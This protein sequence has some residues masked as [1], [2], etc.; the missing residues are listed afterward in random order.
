[1]FIRF[2]KLIFSNILSFG[3]EKTTID[4]SQG[5]HLIVGQNG[6]GKSAILDAL[7]FCLFGQPYRKIKIKEL[8]NRKNRR[9]T[10]VECHFT[11]DNND[12][13]IVIRQIKPDRISILKN[14]QELDLL[15]SKKLNQDE[16]DKIIGIDY[17]MFKQVI[18]L[19]VNYNKPFLSLPAM[20]KRDIVE[21]IFNIK[22]FGQMM[23]IHK[24]NNTDIRI[25]VDMN[26]QSLTIYEE[27]IKSLRRRLKETK[28]ATENFEKNK[29][30]DVKNIQDRI[31]QKKQNKEKLTNDINTNKSLFDAMEDCSDIDS[32][33]EDREDIINKI[34]EKE[35]NV[36]RFNKNIGLIDKNTV[37]T[38]CNQDITNEV[39]D[40]EISRLKV[41]I[42]K[43]NNALE[44][45]R[46]ERITIEQSIDKKEKI[47]KDKETIV[48]DNQ[49]KQEQIN[50]ID[51]EI[52]HLL[53]Q[54]GEIEDRIINFNLDST[55]I[56][57]D[58]KVAEYQK[59][60]K[61]NGS[62]KAKLK[63]NEIVSNILSENGIKSF[64]FKKLTPILNSKVNKYI[65]IFDLPVRIDFDEYMNERITN[66]ENLRRDVSYYAYSEGEK[67]R[68]DTAILLAFI[69]VTKAICNWRSNVIIF[70]E[71]LDSAVD[72]TGLDK[73]ITCLKQI[74]Q[75]D[76]MCGYVISHRL[77]DA[78]GFSS[79]FE[80]TK[81]SIGFSNIHKL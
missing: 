78:N 6:S 71:L 23:K 68:I 47:K 65:Q 58:I 52:S 24:N 21:S 1:M 56:E 79:R 2:D 44:P 62:L 67:K 20:E 53:S 18:S 63:N 26:D 11:I 66:I 45:L 35:Y 25:K 38:L 74:S 27:N 34:N 13:Y 15:S 59:L 81:D 51:D 49:K 72:D 12:K 29:I 80:I 40:Q 54:K 69:D 3:A 76:G 5:F 73:M 77:H 39:K 10:Y 37:C 55:Q 9:N 61:D 4:F 32:L 60:W 70:D 17:S 41:L 36:K 75:A 7:S 16:I 57:F 22:I 64:L 19:A 43:M 42:D 28:E 14:D 31:D 33:K 46:N 8:I 30:N 50:M 48:R